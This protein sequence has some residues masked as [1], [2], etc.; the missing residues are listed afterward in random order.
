MGTVQL[1][2]IVFKGPLYSLCCTMGHLSI[3][4]LWYPQGSQNPPRILRE[5]FNCITFTYLSN[6]RITWLSKG[7]P[8]ANSSIT[9]KCVRNA[10]SEA[11][12]KTGL[13][14]G[15]GMGTQRCV[16]LVAQMVK[17]LPAMQETLV[18]SLGWEDPWKKGISNR[19]SILAW[20]IPWTEEPGRLQSIGVAK[21][22]T[23]LSD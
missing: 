20:K 23:Q 13:V 15:F 3:R 10:D 19:S 18:Q 8:Q 6:T 22:H 5:N 12:L 4:C 9:W 14:V 17:N 11:P 2:T 16:S 21:S 7:G 1:K